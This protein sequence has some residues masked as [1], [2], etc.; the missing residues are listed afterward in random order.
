MRIPFKYNGLERNFEVP[1]ATYD[2]V[3]DDDGTEHELGVE[4]FIRIC[5]NIPAIQKSLND[6]FTKP[7]TIEEMTKLIFMVIHP[8]LM[9]YAKS[10]KTQMGLN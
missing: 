4:G 7:K 8:E 3:E 10:V 1:V 9:A 5:Q 2:I 6:R